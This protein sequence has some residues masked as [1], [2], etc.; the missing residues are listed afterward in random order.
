GAT[1][2]VVLCDLDE[3][4]L[5]SARARVEG[6][7][8]A[9]RVI[10]FHGSFSDAPRRLT[11]LGLSADMVLADLGFASNQV[12]APD[13]GFSFSRDGPL[14]MRLDRS[15]PITAAE[16]VN[17]LPARELAEILRDFGEERLAR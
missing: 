14:D 8:D 17:T 2:T 12:D 11:E 13:R 6:L 1:G 4:N 5:A 15:S 9:P 10:A 3:S 7:P 16:L